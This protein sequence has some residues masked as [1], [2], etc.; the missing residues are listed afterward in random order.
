MHTPF[1]F[2]ESLA[3]DVTLFDPK[4]VLFVHNFFVLLSNCHK[5][6]FKI[7]PPIPIS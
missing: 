2:I 1:F 7:A 5:A 4:L 3:V 6:S